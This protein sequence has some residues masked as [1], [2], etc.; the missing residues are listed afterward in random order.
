MNRKHMLLGAATSATLALGGLVAG[1]TGASSAAAASTGSSGPAMPTGL[2]A[3]S[4]PK[5]VVLNPATGQ[6]VSVS[7]GEPSDITSEA[8]ASVNIGP[9]PDISSGT[10]CAAGDGCYYTP[11]VN[12]TYHDRSFSGSAGTFTGSWPMRNAW[13]SGN[14]TAYVCWTGACSSDWFGPNS[15]VTFGGSTVTGTS[16]TI[17]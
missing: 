8:A 2:L 10:N 6:V 13:D 9:S 11:T 5:T 12:D 4:T 15:Y 16:F 17:K 14:Y 7:T 3:S 1:I